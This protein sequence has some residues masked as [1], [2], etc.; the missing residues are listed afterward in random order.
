[1][2]AVLQT[3]VFE[4][5]LDGLRDRKAVAA[6]RNRILRI[7]GGLFGDVRSLGGRVSEARIDYGPGYRLYF[8]MQGLVAVIL[9]CGGDKSSQSRDVRKAKRMASELDEDD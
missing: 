1:M 6:V 4:E 7:K 2:P 5:W 3:E 9:L 8:T